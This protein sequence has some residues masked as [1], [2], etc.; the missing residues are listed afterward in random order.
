[1]LFRSSMR[2]TGVVVLAFVVWHLLDLTLG[3]TNT[4]GTD[5]EFVKAEVYDNVVRSLGRWPVAL[6]YVV[7]NVLLGLHL[8][9]GAWSIFQSLGWSNPRFNAWRRAFASGF[10]GVVVV[11]NVSFPVAVTLGIVG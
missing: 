7:A 10:A 2:W 5:G 11:G 6:F 1:M 3:V 8:R 4:I 9:H